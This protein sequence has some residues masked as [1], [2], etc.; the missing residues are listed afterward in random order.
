MRTIG[1]LGGM[2]WESTAHYYRLINQGVRDILGG[3]HSAEL[4]LRSIDFDAVAQAQREGAWDRATDWLIQG[5]RSVES[6]GAGCL[7]IGAN[8]MHK[9]A[10]EVARAIHIP[11]LHIADATAEVLKAQ[12]IDRVGLLGTAFTMEQNFY[13]G[14]LKE[15]FGVDVVVPGHTDRGE[16][17]RVIYEE[18]CLGRIEPASKAKYLGV[19]ARLGEQGA[20]AVILG[21]TE[22]GMLI[23]N[24]D[25][26]MLLVDTTAVHA[27]K[28]VEWA[29]ASE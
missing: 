22:I 7:L 8:T 24:S 13:K 11:L 23:E 9:V 3:L 18:L 14:R 17:H 2:S 21:C 15:R 12:G 5:A 25:T 20:Q 1:L 29:L 16:V 28:A 10:D 19:I 26:E 6:A 4:V 27:A